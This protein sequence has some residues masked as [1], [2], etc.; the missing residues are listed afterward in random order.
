ML[1]SRNAD[2]HRKELCPF[3]RACHEACVP[4]LREGLLQKGKLCLQRY[5]CNRA[6]A[7]LQADCIQDQGERL[8]E[9]IR[10]DKQDEIRL[11]ESG[12]RRKENRRVFKDGSQKRII[13]VGV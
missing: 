1:L 4:F 13:S 11:R 2:I 10:P 12:L 7:C 8:A 5:D 3:L 9:K 6:W